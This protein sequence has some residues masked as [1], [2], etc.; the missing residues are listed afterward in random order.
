MNNALLVSKLC[1]SFANGITLILRGF[2]GR[3]H[4][5]DELS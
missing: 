2:L 4:V 1:L 5:S 3:E